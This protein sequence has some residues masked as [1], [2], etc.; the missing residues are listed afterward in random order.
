MFNKLDMRYLGRYRDIALLLFRHGGREL[1]HVTG[2]DT[3]LKPEDQAHQ[4]KDAA[5]LTA[6]LERLGP[7]FVKLGQ[8]M[9]GRADLLPEPYLDAL[10]RLHGNV[11]PFGFDQVKQI[12]EEELGQPLE[13]IYAAFEEKPL[14]AASIGQ[15]H[16]AT[17]LS[18]EAV[19]VKVQRPGAKKTIDLDLRAMEQ[20]AGLL[21]EHTDVGR[22]YRFK[23]LLRQ[24]ER[25]IRHELDY[26]H[27]ADNL[28]LIAQNLSGFDEIVVPRPFSELTTPRVLTMQ[29][30]SGK[31]LDEAG[32][33]ALPKERAEELADAFF[34]AYLCQIVRDG[35]FHADPHPGNLI[36]TDDQ[37]LGLID[38]GMVGRVSTGMQEDILRLLVALSEG[39][40]VEAADACQELGDR[41]EAYNGAEYRAN[42]REAITQDYGQSI[43]SMRLGRL[44][45]RVTRLAADAGL[46][47]APEVMLLGKTLVHLDESGRLLAPEFNTNDAMRRHASRLLR[48]KLVGSVSLGQAMVTALQTKQFVNALPR[49]INK[50]LDII[51]DNAFR[52][53]VDSLDEDRL[54]EVIEKI[55]NRVTIGLVVASTIL[56]GALLMD[57]ESPHM[58]WGYPVVGMIL[59]II[60]LCTGALVLA[61]VLWNDFIK[62]S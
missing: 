29:F 19:V 38:L 40:T 32:A 62:G 52:M 53:K 39:R 57:G 1:L 61:R 7:T 9:A 25:A 47:V 17:L 13:T 48:K 37:R 12:I 20:V 36:L 15:A 4:Q 31:T 23:A 60:G 41:T 42:I 43:G 44:V 56:A 24:F 34:N 2:L 30:L 46:R 54:I 28:E 49:R 10:R 58:L 3:V 11:E 8:L 21:D 35:V 33:N 5:E 50:V 16:R 59:L 6:D 26:T 51:A 18:G 22:R 14:A 45:L 27:E 55:A